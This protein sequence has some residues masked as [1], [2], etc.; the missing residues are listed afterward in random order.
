[1]TERPKP[2]TIICIFGFIISVL[3]ILNLGYAMIISFK[4]LSS[5]ND[6]LKGQTMELIGVAGG[7]GII[8][9]VIGLIG[10]YFLWN[11]QKKGLKLFGIFIG[12]GIIF[13]ANGWIYMIVWL[14]IWGSIYFYLHKNRDLLT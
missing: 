3:I 13:Y 11:M 8:V 2:I 9:A 14:V 7:L 12:L 10:F 6:I 5:S 4:N 1:M